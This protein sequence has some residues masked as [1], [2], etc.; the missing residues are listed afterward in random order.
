MKTKFS[1]LSMDEPSDEQLHEIMADA[2]VEVKLLN[3]KAKTKYNELMAA[4]LT[5][6][7][8]RNLKNVFGNENK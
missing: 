8:E 7:R 3:E 6:A 4:E 1:L 5:I 2:L